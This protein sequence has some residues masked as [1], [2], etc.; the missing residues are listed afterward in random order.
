MPDVNVI[1]SRVYRTLRPLHN[2]HAGGHHDILIDPPGLN[3]VP[4]DEILGVYV[5]VP[6]KRD[7]AIV[8]SVHGMYV[9]Q[10]STWTFVAYEDIAEV[11][12][13]DPEK[14]QARH[15]QLTLAHGQTLLLL[16][17]GGDEK[18]RDV[19]EVVRFLMRVIAHTRRSADRSVP[20]S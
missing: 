19:F 3:L 18:F 2:F 10:S 11:A 14:R 6:G 16:V 17:T 5:N 4:G 7:H 8:V 1:K 15:L 20:D 12:V 13:P 9:D